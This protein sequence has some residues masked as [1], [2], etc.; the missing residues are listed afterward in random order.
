MSTRASREPDRSPVHEVRGG[1]GHGRRI[2]RGRSDQRE[3]RPC[4]AR[5]GLA[6]S[7][8]SALGQGEEGGE[9]QGRGGAEG[10]EHLLRGV[11]SGASVPNLPSQR[12]SLLRPLWT[13]FGRRMAPPWS[14]EKAGT[15]RRCRLS[16]PAPS[17]RAERT[18]PRPPPAPCAEARVAGLPGAEPA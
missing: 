1:R 15:R 3:S 10:G 12:H 14:M 16:S 5:T 18:P 4:S 7:F 9:A 11:G 2:G 8:S 17:D 13:G 6:P